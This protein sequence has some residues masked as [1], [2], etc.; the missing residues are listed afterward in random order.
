MATGRENLHISTVFD[1][2]LNDGETAA[3]SAKSAERLASALGNC[4]VFYADWLS[5]LELSDYG[6]AFT[7]NEIDGAGLLD[8]SDSDLD[9]LKVKV[10]KHR[11]TIMCGVQELKN[12]SGGRYLTI[13]ETSVIEQ[14]N[15]TDSQIA[16]ALQ[17]NDTVKGMK[18]TSDVLLVESGGRIYVSPLTYRGFKIKLEASVCVSIFIYNIYSNLNYKCV[19]IY[20]TLT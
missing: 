14:R 16:E 2:I 18:R 12:N 15:K 19:Y 5:S 10:L 3:K 11:K 6:P 7:L 4:K 8:L 13:G 17:L 9:Y 1:Y 20:H